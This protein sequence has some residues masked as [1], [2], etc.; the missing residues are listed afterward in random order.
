MIYRVTINDKINKYTFTGR[1]IYSYIY[2]LA[3]TK[4][5][6]DMI[7]KIILYYNN[8]YYLEAVQKLLSRGHK[9]Y[10]EIVGAIDKMMNREEVVYIEPIT[11][12]T[13]KSA[14]I[15]QLYLEQQ[16]TENTPVPPVTILEP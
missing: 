9:N 7:N 4:E 6:M 5:A 12:I 14:K 1:H 11:L 15:L 8:S 3:E 13:E 2:L 16:E 10:S